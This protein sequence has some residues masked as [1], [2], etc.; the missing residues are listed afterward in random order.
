MDF[1]YTYMQDQV[2]VWRWEQSRIKRDREKKQSIVYGRKP[3]LYWL[4]QLI[5]TIFREREK[6]EE[7]A[8]FNVRMTTGTT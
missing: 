2:D 6:W 4:L 1:K 7:Y 3:Q 5:L 8:K